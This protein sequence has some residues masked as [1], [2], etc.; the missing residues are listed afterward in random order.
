MKALRGALTTLESSLVRAHPQLRI[1]R[2][3]ST[4]LLL[5]CLQI[6]YYCLLLTILH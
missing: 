6:C 4:S 5:F 2:L 3:T 1:P